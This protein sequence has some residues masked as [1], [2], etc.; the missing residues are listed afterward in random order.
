MVYSNREPTSYWG[1]NSGLLMQTRFLRERWAWMHSSE[2]PGCTGVGAW[3][4]RCKGFPDYWAWMRHS[5]W[6]LYKLAGVGLG[7]QMQTGSESW[8]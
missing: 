1:G 2:N 8:A 3:A 7:S 5:N 4:P 6:L